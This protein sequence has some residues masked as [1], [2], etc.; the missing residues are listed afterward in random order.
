MAL[1]AAVLGC[2]GGNALDGSIG[3]AF[4]LSF[5]TVEL[6]RSPTAFQVTYLQSEGREVVARITVATAGLDLGEP[7]ELGGEYAPG[8]SRTT[9]TRAVDGSPVLVLPRVG[10]GSM[11]L[12]A[13]PAAGQVVSGDFSLSFAEGGDIGA[14]RTLSGSFEGEVLPAR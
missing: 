6:R 4:D 5:S 3:E 8:H 7:I 9:V 2:S 14:G 12:D 13:L 11:E 1:L 10:S